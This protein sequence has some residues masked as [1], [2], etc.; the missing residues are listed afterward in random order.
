MEQDY[1]LIGVANFRC[2]VITVG[3]PQR[4]SYRPRQD[5]AQCASADHLGAMGSPNLVN[6]CVQRESPQVGYDYVS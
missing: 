1:L 5:R 3:A 6:D 4:F 2:A